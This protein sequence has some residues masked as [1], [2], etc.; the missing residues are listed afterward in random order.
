MSNV[1]SVTRDKQS[2]SAVEHGKLLFTFN[3]SLLPPKTQECDTRVIWLESASTVTQRHWTLENPAARRLGYSSGTDILHS[4]LRI[5]CNEC[6]RR[7]SNRKRSFT[8]PRHV[9]PPRLQAVQ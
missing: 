7:T 9:P 1:I 3:C 4:L 8:D 5:T 2:Q 6:P